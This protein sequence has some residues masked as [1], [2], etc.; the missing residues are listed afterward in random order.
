MPP[1]GWLP[2]TGE[3]LRSLVLG[4]LDQISKHC[5]TSAMTSVDPTRS[6]SRWD[7]LFALQ[8]RMDAEIEDLYVRR[9][10]AGVRSRF[11]RPLIRLA[12]DGPQTI[13]TLAASLGQT[14]SATSQTVAAMRREGLVETAPGADRRSQVVALTQRSRD[15]LPLME[16]E[17]RATNA[18]VAA[19]DDELGGAVTALIAAL[20]E[21]LDRRSMTERL[22]EALASAA[23]GA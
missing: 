7:G 10:V 21:A 8:R 17:W 4:G 9:G 23:R 3:S 15:A 12:H 5:Y 6:P 14:H 18:V 20:E 19:L 1:P 13:S 2:G 22:D 16:A 11:V